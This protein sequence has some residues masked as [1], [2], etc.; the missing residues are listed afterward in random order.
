MRRQRGSGDGEVV[1]RADDE[2][3]DVDVDAERPR[4]TQVA[5]RAGAAAVASG[6]VPEG[7]PRLPVAALPVEVLPKPPEGLR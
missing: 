1:L 5:G 3:G 2:Q 7:L 6:V 4:G